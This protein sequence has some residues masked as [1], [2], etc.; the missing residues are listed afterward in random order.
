VN[1]QTAEAVIMLAMGDYAPIRERY[2]SIIYTAV[3]EFLSGDKSIASFKNVAKRA[4]QEAFYPA[5]EQGMK[6]GGGEPPLQGE[7]LQWL[8]GRTDAERANIDS[9][10]QSLK[11]LRADPEPLTTDEKFLAANTRADNYATTLDSIYSEAKTRGAGATMLTFGGTDGHAPEF[12]CPECKKLKGQRHRAS[13]WISRGLIPYPGN[14][15]F[16]CGTWQCQ[17]YLYDDTGKVYT[18]PSVIQAGA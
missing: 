10:F 1:T 2:R 12:P 13:W 7:D 4:I 8:N 14:T 6:D 18:L 5:A 11:E 9:M 3:L 16:T 17:H 15:N